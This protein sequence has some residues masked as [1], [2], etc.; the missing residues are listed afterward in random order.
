MIE[1][2]NLT[3]GLFITEDGEELE[4]VSAFDDDGDDC[5]LEDAVACV[6]GPDSDGNWWTI[7][8]TEFETVVMQ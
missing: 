3:D 8:L 2:I 1:A 6:A 7:D 4:I 5:E